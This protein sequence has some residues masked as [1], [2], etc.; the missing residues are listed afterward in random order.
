MNSGCLQVTRKDISRSGTLR[1]EVSYTTNKCILMPFH[2][3]A[4]IHT[5]PFWCVEPDKDI[6]ERIRFRRAVLFISF[7]GHTQTCNI[8]FLLEQTIHWMTSI[9]SKPPCLSVRLLVTSTS[10]WTTVLLGLT[11]TRIWVSQQCLTLT[12]SNQRTI[13]AD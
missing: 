2:V 8:L 7:H 10:R 9:V 5:I 4:F 6:L 13:I 3:L 12:N 11:A 1:Q